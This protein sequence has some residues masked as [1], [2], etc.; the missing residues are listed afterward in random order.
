M[1]SVRGTAAGE[2]ALSAYHKVNQGW[3]F[4]MRSAICFVERPALLLALEDIAYVDFAR[5]NNVSSTFDLVVKLK[6]GGTVEFTQIDR[7][8]LGKL[9]SYVSTARI[10]VRLLGG[11]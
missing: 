11:R 6:D 4:P 10:K 3:L 1:H 7:P 8:D 9:Q 2:T 5:A